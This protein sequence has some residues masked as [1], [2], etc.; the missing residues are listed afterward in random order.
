VAM[1]AEAVAMAAEAE[2]AASAAHAT[3]T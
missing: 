3:K 1:G 2:E